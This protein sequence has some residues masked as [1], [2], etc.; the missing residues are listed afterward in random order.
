[1]HLWGDGTFLGEVGGPADLGGAQLAGAGSVA[2]APATGADLRGRHRPQPGARVRTGSHAPGEWGAGEGDGASGDAPGAFNHPGAVAVAPSGD[3]YVADTGNDRVV[4]LSPSGGVIGEWGSKGHRRRALSLADRYRCGR[5]GARVR[6]GQRK[7]P[8]PGVR[9]RRAPA[10]EMGTRGTAP[11][12]FCQPTAIA[13]GCSGEVFVANTNNNRVER[14]DLVSPAAPGCLA[15]G[16]WPP[17]LNVAPVLQVSLPRAPA[18]SPAARSR[19]QVSCKRGCRILV[20]ASLSAP[21]GATPRPCSPSPAACR[22]RSPA[23]YACGS[24]RS[25]FGACAASSARAGG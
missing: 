17:P 7:Q 15:P 20:T 19:L 9:S 14:F 10:G 24:G 16:S 25:R 8:G 3:V 12:G 21:A 2:V 5:R 6:G 1:M 18:C 4:E 22:R 23:T 11:G 13:V